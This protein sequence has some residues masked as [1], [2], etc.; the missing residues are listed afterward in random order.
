LTYFLIL[1]IFS[2]LTKGEMKMGMKPGCKNSYKNYGLEDLLFWFPFE[3]Y[4]KT[5]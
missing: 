3:Q 4:L 2:A 1:D 5:L